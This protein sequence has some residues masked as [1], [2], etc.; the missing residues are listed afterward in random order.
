MQVVVKRAIDN[1]GGPRGFA[2]MSRGMQEA[3]IDQVCWH[4]VR[5]GMQFAAPGKGPT[6]AEM[7]ETSRVAYEIA[8][9]SDD[10]ES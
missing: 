8:G 9:I 4:V 10:P 2:F 3:I 7:V 1:V 6:F 5:D